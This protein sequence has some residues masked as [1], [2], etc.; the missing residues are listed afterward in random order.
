MTI[1]ER[2]YQ[3]DLRAIVEFEKSR[4][5]FLNQNQFVKEPVKDPWSSDYLKRLNERHKKGYNKTF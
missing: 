3:E 5:R 1:E 4:E 2:D